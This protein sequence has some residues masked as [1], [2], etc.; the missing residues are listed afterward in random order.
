MRTNFQ[1]RCSISYVREC[2]ETVPPH[3]TVRIAQV[4][5]FK[6]WTYLRSKKWLN[7][8]NINQ[9]R[10]YGHVIV[11]LHVHPVSWGR[12]ECAAKAQSRVRRHAAHSLYEP[13]NP[14][15]GNVQ[16]TRKGNRTHVH[17]VEVELLQDFAWVHWFSKQAHSRYELVMN[18]A[19]RKTSAEVYKW[20]T[21]RYQI[22]GS[23]PF[24]CFKTLPEITYLTVV[25][26]LRFHSEA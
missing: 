15:A 26:Y 3:L 7:P 20:H 10:G 12:V 4:L 18:S 8:R 6:S 13:L 25:M 17:R 2:F 21:S 5:W 24:K 22:I 23:C 9:F 1:M 16:A 19:V 14:R 11:G